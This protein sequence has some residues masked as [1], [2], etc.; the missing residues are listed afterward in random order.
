VKRHPFYA[1]IAGLSL[2]AVG[3]CLCRYA[4]TP[5]IPSMI[6]AHW[7]DKPGAGYLS[8][9]NCL[10]YLLGCFAALFLPGSVGVRRLVRISLLLAV[11]GQTMSAWNF[12]FVYLAIARGITGFGGASLV[13]HT[14]AVVLLHVPENWKK[15]ALGVVFS[16]AGA[17]IVLVCLV[18]PFFLSISL[19]A[20]W[21]FEAGLTFLCAVIAWPLTGSAPTAAAQQQAGPRLP[22]EWGAKRSLVLVGTAYFLASIGITPHMLFLTDYLHRHFGTSVAES[23]QLFSLVGVGSLV[24]AL[25]SGVVARWFGTPLALVANYLLG[26]VAVLLVLITTSVTVITASAFMMGFFLLCCVALSS[27]RTGE[28]SGAARHPH[29]WG[30]LTLGFGLGLAIGSY[31]LSGLLSLGVSYWMLFVIA[32]GIL[33]VALLFSIWVLLL[34]PQP[35]GS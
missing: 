23:S 19:T 34:R 22:L 33:A 20:G 30:I 21:L 35:H 5:L 14:P 27:I 6:N 13:I 10:G 24:G 26:A 18:L 31:G 15:I 8:G 4:Y 7:V 9:F 28:I 32:Q 11:V 29:D 17:S 25:T 16:G 12:G 3:L 2:I 1:T